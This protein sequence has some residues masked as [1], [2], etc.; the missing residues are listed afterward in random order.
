[1][2]QNQYDRAKT[3]RLWILAQAPKTRP[4]V[5]TG[6]PECPMVS[7][8]APRMNSLTFM[9]Y[10]KYFIVVISRTLFAYT[11]LPFEF[12]ITISCSSVG[13]E[14]IKDYARQM[15][16]FVLSSINYPWLALMTRW[17]QSWYHTFPAIGCSDGF[18]KNYRKSQPIGPVVCSRFVFP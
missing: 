2:I 4:Y 16:S 10:G 6:C 15:A 9:K 11:S 12:H 13:M 5:E 17:A 7:E 18:I 8:I 1:M 3:W 14:K